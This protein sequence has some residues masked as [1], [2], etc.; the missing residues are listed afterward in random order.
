VEKIIDACYYHIITKEKYPVNATEVKD[1]Y[2]TAILNLAYDKDKIV[3]VL[4][5]YACI[6][7]LKNSEG[8]LHTS[9]AEFYNEVAAEIIEKLGGE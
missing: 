3:E 6:C 8:E 5:S 9:L 2:V 4:S 1:K 7:G